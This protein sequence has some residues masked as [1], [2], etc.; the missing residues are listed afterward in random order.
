MWKPCAP[1]PVARL[2]YSRKDAPG[3]TQTALTLRATVGNNVNRISILVAFTHNFPILIGELRDRYRN[4]RRKA[5]SSLNRNDCSGLQTIGWCYSW[6]SDTGITNHGCNKTNFEKYASVSHYIGRNHC[7]AMF[8]CLSGTNRSYVC[9]CWDYADKSV[10]IRSNRDIVASYSKFGNVGSS[11]FQ[12]YL[13][14]VA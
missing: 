5:L 10:C 14:L 3:S 13:C 8:A 6:P 9:K 12:R 11:A 4:S 1:R 2:I 7:L